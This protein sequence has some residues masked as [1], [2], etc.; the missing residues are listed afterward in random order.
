MDRQNNKSVLTPIQESLLILAGLSNQI[1]WAID[2][3][4]LE[5]RIKDENLKFT[6]SNHIHIILCSFLEEWHTLEKL[7]VDKKLIVILKITSPALSRIRKWKGLTKVR[8][9]LLAHGHRDKKGMLVCPWEVFKEYNAPTAY[10][11]TMLLGKCAL[12][13]TKVLLKYYKLEYNTAIQNFSE[14][15]RKIMD[16]GIRTIKDIDAELEQ[17]TNGMLHI[18]YSYN[19][20]ELERLF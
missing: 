15:K 1:K 20:S 12:L 7:G 17:V 4:L 5:D 2:S 3:V 11:E 16:K 9:I 14:T 19:D 13:A 6:I 10:A 18:A 8:S